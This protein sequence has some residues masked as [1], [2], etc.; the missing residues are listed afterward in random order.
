MLD[1]DNAKESILESIQWTESEVKEF[2]RKVIVDVATSKMTF[3][4]YLVQDDLRTIR[5]T[6]VLSVDGPAQPDVFSMLKRRL[7]GTRVRMTFGNHSSGTIMRLGF[8]ADR[9]FP[10]PS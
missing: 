3:D 9:F 2:V 10:L 7:E 1:P 5:L 6:A 4:P 8:E